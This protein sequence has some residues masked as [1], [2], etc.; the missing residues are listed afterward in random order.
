MINVI[1]AWL[2]VFP[3]YFQIQA[4]GSAYVDSRGTIQ[5]HG[6]H[7]SDCESVLDESQTDAEVCGIPINE[8]I[9]ISHSFGLDHEPSDT[10]L[11]R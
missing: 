6:W 4:V 5:V 7:F 8:L 1:L 3:H 9:G 11:T 10:G 2:M